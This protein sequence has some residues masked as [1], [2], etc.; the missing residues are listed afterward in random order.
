MS[1]SFDQF[2]FPI[3]FAVQNLDVTFVIAEDE[4]IAIAKLSLFDCFF[5]CHGTQRHGVKRADYVGFCYGYSG[6]K[7]MHSDRNCR[8]R[9]VLA[10]S[11]SVG[12]RFALRHASAA[13]TRHCRLL[14]LFLELRLPFTGTLTV[15]MPRCLGFRLGEGI[16]QRGLH[17]G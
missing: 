13:A 15:T 1:G 3:A 17:A 2:H 10:V 9:M 12:S 5:E 14:N 11:R 7:G 8:W 16:M 6:R 4:D